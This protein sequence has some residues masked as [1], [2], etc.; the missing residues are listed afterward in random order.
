[1]RH[2]DRIIELEALGSIE[3]L[4]E[5]IDLRGAPTLTIREIISGQPVRCSFPEDYEQRVRDLLRKRVRVSGLI[6]YFADG[7]PKRITDFDGIE[8]MTP[9][10]NLTPAGFGSIPDLTDGR[11]AEHHLRLVRGE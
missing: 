6:H 7:R 10:R 8:D 9:R 3:G 5:D 1:M 2:E 4:L 11:G